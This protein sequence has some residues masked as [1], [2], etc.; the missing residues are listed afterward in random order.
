MQT[1]L[2]TAFFGLLSLRMIISQRKGI[3]LEKYFWI[4]SVFLLSGF[5]IAVFP[6]FQTLISNKLG[7]V[8]PSN[9]L[10]VSLVASTTFWISELVIAISKQ[11]RVAR[12]L[13]SR[14]SVIET[15]LL[16]IKNKIG[17]K[18]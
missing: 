6:S 10:I 13:V 11:V 15:E 17:H 4:W 2:L 7:F 14:V 18:N 8:L 12:M 16:T 1:L 3:L 9:F 5:V